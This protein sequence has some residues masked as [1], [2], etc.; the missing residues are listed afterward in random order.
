MFALVAQVS[1]SK[2]P[3][4]SP[5]ASRPCSTTPCRQPASPASPAFFSRSARSSYRS[6]S[7]WAPA[8]SSSSSPTS[9]PSC[10]TIGD[11][12]AKVW[13]PKL[14]TC[15]RVQM[16]VFQVWTQNITVKS[17]LEEL[18]CTTTG[19]QQRKKISLSTTSVC[20]VYEEKNQWS[21]EVI[22]I[23]LANNLHRYK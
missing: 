17:A 2:S 9:S 20:T 4:A 23:R 8:S 19:V 15:T 6:A 22:N 13:E 18:R 11:H 16:L 10:R 7:A 12:P 14:E 1:S 21:S 3:A 5:Q